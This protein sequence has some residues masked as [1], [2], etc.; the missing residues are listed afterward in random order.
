[1]PSAVRAGAVL[2]TLVALAA[3]TKPATNAPSAAAAD[4]GRIGYVRM[5]DLV[6]VHPRYSELV[7][8]DESIEALNLRAVVPDVAKP[9]AAIVK[10]EAALQSEL[11]AAAEH[12]RRVLADKSR[13][14]QL[15]EEQAIALALRASGGQAPSAAEIA[16][17][18]DATAQLQTSSVAAQA[19]RDFTTYR[20]TLEAADTAE[21]RAAQAALAGRADRMYRAKQDQLQAAESSLS[22]A[23]A[24]RDAAERLSLR[25]RLSSLA[26]DDDARD[27]VRNELAAIDR[28]EAD[29]IG[30][31][32]NRDAQTLAA[33][34]AELRAS[35]ARDMRA[36]AAQIHARSVAKLNV[37]EA[38]L[39]REFTGGAAAVAA[40]PGAGPGTAR[41]DLTPQ[42]R[43]T[44]KAL[45]ENY[46]KQ[47]NAD[48]KSTIDEFKRTRDD[49]QRRYEGLRGIDASAQSGAS[50]QVATLTK[51]RADLYSQIV[52]QIGREV[53]LLAAAR[54]ISV[55]VTDP[56]A[57][58]GG[59]DLTPDAEKDIESL[60]E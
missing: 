57:N 55:V 50:A 32:K 12:T 21:L 42:L 40:I 23:Q 49:L 44:L 27:A 19:N 46:Q 20:K 34:A 45:H 7:G 59:V 31:M 4:S 11:G 17:Q 18:I 36:K 47:F 8:Y 26:L 1:M 52:A 43:A 35:V 22:L 14:Y 2:L 3:C 24:S 54:G 51:K 39:R 9:D 37:R 28:R 30:A 29:A 41:T 38:D 16:R 60:H 25:T 53:R 58:A 10:A 13:V 6:K 15:R 48:A 56:V 5:T 33:Y